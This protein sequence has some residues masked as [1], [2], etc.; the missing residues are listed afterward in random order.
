MLQ[1]LYEVILL[2]VH[3]IMNIVWDVFVFCA[4]ENMVKYTQKIV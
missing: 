3:D 2:H 1:I 4:N